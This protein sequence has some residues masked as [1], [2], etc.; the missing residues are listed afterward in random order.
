MI[1]TTALET[2][3]FPQQRACPLLAERVAGTQNSAQPQ[4]KKSYD[5]M[6]RLI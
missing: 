6:I 4:S 1:A 3:T 2:S 5:S